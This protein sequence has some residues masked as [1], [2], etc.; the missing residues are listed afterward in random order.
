MCSRLSC[1]GLRDPP[2]LPAAFSIS[3]EN[4]SEN[5]SWESN[6][7]GMIKWSKAQS[8]NYQL[9][10]HQSAKLSL[11]CIEFWIG[12]PVNSSRF[13]HWRDKSDRHRFEE[14][15][16]IAWASSRIIYCHFIPW[17]YFSSWTAC[18]SADTRGSAQQTQSHVNGIQLSGMRLDCVATESEAETIWWYKILEKGRRKETYKLIWGND[19]MKRTPFTKSHILPTPNFP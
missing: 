17:K 8:S 1:S 12:V 16:L 14:L 10:L 3:F 5:S 19:N 18:L 13:R 6:R 9:A 15:D 4:H 2:P 11:P 7:E